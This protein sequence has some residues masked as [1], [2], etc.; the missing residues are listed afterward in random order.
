M[1]RDAKNRCGEQARVCKSNYRTLDS[2]ANRP[3]AGTTWRDVM[4]SQRPRLFYIYMSRDAHLAFRLTAVTVT[5]G[6]TRDHAD[7]ALDIVFVIQEQTLQRCCAHRVNQPQFR[8]L[9]HEP[10]LSFTSHIELSI[11][12][13]P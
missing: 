11:E 9:R 12:T 4:R 10:L 2:Y 3:D 6:E 8:D 13:I 7:G 5:S 1:P